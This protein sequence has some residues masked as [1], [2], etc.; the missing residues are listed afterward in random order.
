MAM[1]LEDLNS[2]GSGT[3]SGMFQLPIHMTK[4][5]PYISLSI[6]GMGEPSIVINGSFP[7]VYKAILSAIAKLDAKWAKMEAAEKA[8][9]K[10]AKKALSEKALNEAPLTHSY[11]FK[12]FNQPDKHFPIAASNMPLLDVDYGSPLN[13]IDPGVEDDPDLI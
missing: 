3:T 10:A 12:P 11:I 2:I 8:E 4:H 13:T 9:L 6:T 7:I 5:E 1:E